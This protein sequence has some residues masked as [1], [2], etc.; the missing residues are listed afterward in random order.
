MRFYAGEDILG[1][2]YGFM[3]LRHEVSTCAQLPFAERLPRGIP[4]ADWIPAVAELGMVAI[5]NNR[6]TRTNPVEA[7]IAVAS[8]ARI[9]GPAGKAANGCVAPASRPRVLHA[10]DHRRRRYDEPELALA[11][12]A[13]EDGIPRLA[14]DAIVLSDARGLRI[15]ADPL[16]ALAVLDAPLGQVFQDDPSKVAASQRP[17]RPAVLPPMSRTRPARPR[18]GAGRPITTAASGW[19]G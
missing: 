11:R 15:E 3:W 2:G 5:T 14:G 13:G 4:D 7:G 9:I 10:G 8:G 17:R 16:R 12:H 1:L 6:K 18:R 19:A